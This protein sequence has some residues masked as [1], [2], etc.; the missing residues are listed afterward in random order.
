VLR[1]YWRHRDTLVRY[2]ASPIQ[3]MQKALE[4]M[5]VQIH[6]VISDITG[7]TGMRILQALLDGE[8]DR[9][10]LAALKRS[11]RSK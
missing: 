2:A 7:V 11:S 5:N 3:H 6:K 9:Q 4:Q 10:K 8:R 1:S